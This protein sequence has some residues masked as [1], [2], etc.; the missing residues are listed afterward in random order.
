M[1]IS[2]P[3]ANTIP[4]S[5]ASEPQFRVDQPNHEMRR[6]E[7]YWEPE[8]IGRDLGAGFASFAA[9]DEHFEDEEMVVDRYT[10]AQSGS[11]AGQKVV[12]SQEGR[13]LSAQLGAISRPQSDGAI[14]YEP[15]PPKTASFLWPAEGP[16]TVEAEP[17]VEVET[18]YPAAQE[19]VTTAVSMNLDNLQFDEL[20][21]NDADLI[22]VEDDPASPQGPGRTTLVKRQEY[23]QLFAKLRKGPDA[24]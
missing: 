1:A 2:F 10:I 18:W 24:L 5:M 23:S 14:P 6:L 20:D 7:E 16:E 21:P 13:E 17:V 22:I 11:F 15:S 4:R 12:S 19:R 3:Q 9:F 8:S